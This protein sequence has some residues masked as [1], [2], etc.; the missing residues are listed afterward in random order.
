MSIGTKFTR[1]VIVG[2]VS[3][4]LL[5]LAYLLLTALGLGLKTWQAMLACHQARGM[6]Q[7]S[8]S[9]SVRNVPV[10][11]QFSPLQFRFSPPEMAVH[12][13]PL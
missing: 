11:K 7:V 9:M 10:L 4:V 6:E 1:F 13:M 2:L 8:T 12:W 3:N 5:Y